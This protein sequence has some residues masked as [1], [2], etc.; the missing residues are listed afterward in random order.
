MKLLENNK[1]PETT[2][3]EEDS[4]TAKGDKTSG[5]PALCGIMS[6]NPILTV[7]VFA[8]AGVAIGIGLSTWVPEDGS[9]SKETAVQWIGLIGDMFIRALKATVL[10]LVFV[11]VIVSIVDM[12]SV[13]KAGTIGFRT[14]LLYTVTTLIASIIGL[15]SILSFKSLFK[16]EIPESSTSARVQLGCDSEGSFLTYDIADGNVFCSADASNETSNYFNIV[17]ID[18]TFASSS[19]GPANDI[20]VSQQIYDGVFG[21]LI[22]SNIFE[23]FVESNF[24]AVRQLSALFI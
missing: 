5:A 17:D 12:M 2:M 21:K 23:S 7:L 9:T 13:G 16:T 11:N 6:R 10:P 3:S 15:I 20:S 14:V 18:G 19:S 24:A 1:K 8:A 22:T 4:A